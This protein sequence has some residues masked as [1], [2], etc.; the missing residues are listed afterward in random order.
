MAAKKPKANGQT[1]GTKRVR[2]DAREWTVTLN[3]A[4]DPGADMSRQGIIRHDRCEI[5][6]NYIN[7]DQ[8]LIVM[9]HELMHE[10]LPGVA[11]K[12]ID[13]GDSRLK[14][15]LESHGVDLSPLLKGFK[16]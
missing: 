4:R 6:V 11:E 12:A 16:P 15:A 9:L 14:D 13:L 2:F 8:A 1:F 5:E 3:D 10:A 7:H